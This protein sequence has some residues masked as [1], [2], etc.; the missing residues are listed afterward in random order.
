MAAEQF[1]TL[2]AEYHRKKW[3][4][5]K[6]PD[7][8]GEFID[9]ISDDMI[10]GIHESWKK[11]QLRNSLHTAY[12]I[13]R[14]L[15]EVRFADL[16]AEY[17]VSMRE[18]L[19]E[20]VLPEFALYHLRT[21]AED[22]G[23]G[24][25]DK[26]RR[27]SE[28]WE[29]V[30]ASWWHAAGN[31]ESQHADLLDA[32][33]GS[34][35]FDR[36]TQPAILEEKLRATKEFFSWQ[37][38]QL[39]AGNSFQDLLRY[40][41]LDSLSTSADWNDLPALAK[42]VMELCHIRKSPRLLKSENPAVQFLYV[43]EPPHRLVLEHG[44]GS[45]FDS[46]RFLVELGKGF[47]YAGHN[48]ALPAEERLCGD[49]SLPWFWGYLY[50][51]LLVE[52]AGIRSLIGASAEVF[53]NHTDFTFHVS[54]RHDVMLG[55]YNCGL[56][57]QWKNAQDYFVTL[58]ENAVPVPAPQHLYLYELSH[59]TE[60]F[61]RARAQHCARLAARALRSRYGWN[62]F[63]SPKWAGRA[64]DYWWEGFRLTLSDVLSDLQI[65]PTDEYAFL[66][67]E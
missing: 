59:S 37:W 67:I 57:G 44:R 53:A 14:I 6:Y 20:N 45:P 32:Y 25:W 60:S 63:A 42:G 52:P 4:P 3:F 47:F 56:P 64:R 9:Y 23:D 54:Y 8:F 18:L 11:D 29:S 30:Q 1:R 7:P 31:C 36:K 48:P 61:F 40:F 28:K 24:L 2:L 15:P 65:A 16:L 33:S 10:S 39:N 22:P 50:S 51:R 66:A 26:L 19:D 62:W 49:P 38:K 55:L 27:W 43:I 46:L 21:R 17:R 41:R 12:T 58:W 13:Y 34:L 35:G 5:E